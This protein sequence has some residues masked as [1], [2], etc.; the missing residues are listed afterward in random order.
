MGSPTSHST[1]TSSGPGWIQ[2]DVGDHVATVTLNRPER[3][4][5]MPPEMRLDLWRTLVHLDRSDEVRAIVLTGAGRGFCG[6]SDT[7]RLSGYTAADVSRRF[8]EHEYGSDTIL[9][10]DTPV[11]AAVNGAAAGL[12]FA[13]AVMADV[14]FSVP[15]AKWTTAFARLGLCAEAGLSVLLPRLIGT[16]WASDLLLTAR[17]LCGTEAR[18]IGLVQ[19]LVEPD[20]LLPTAQQYAHTIARNSTYSVRTIRRQLREDADLDLDAVLAR[21]RSTVVESIAGPDFAEAQSAMVE[22]REPRFR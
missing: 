4:N 13:I 17:T 11:I 8:S 14:R 16:G 2:V 6:G 12:G 20:E 19:Y 9:T 5:A 1:H 22:R 21:T 18:A 3:L 15:D 7:A 10:L